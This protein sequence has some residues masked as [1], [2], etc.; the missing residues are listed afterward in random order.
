MLAFIFLVL[1][2]GAFWFLKAL[3]GAASSGSS[4]R[5]RAE[6]RVPDSRRPVATRSQASG[7]RITPRY[8]WLPP[9]ESIEV[10]GTLLNGGMLYV[11]RQLAGVA[12]HYE[13]EPA[14]I[15]PSLPIGIAPPSLGD[16]GMG[17]WP[18]YS[19]IA[20]SARRAYLAWLASGRSQTGVDIGLV[21]LFFY[22]LERRALSE[23]RSSS[24]ARAEL[25]QIAAEVER[26]L[27]IY[28]QN[29]SFRSYC[30]DFLAAVRM[31]AHGD[32][33]DAPPGASRSYEIPFRLKYLLGRRAQEG[34][35]VPSDL[36]FE[37]VES[38]PEIYLRTPAERC[39][40]DFR[41]LFAARYAERFGGGLTLRR[42]KRRLS[43]E[44]RPASPSF[45][46]PIRIDVGD[47]PD[48]SALKQPVDRLRELAATTEAELDSYSRYL[49]RRPEDGD[50]L[51]ALALL[52]TELLR[53]R[54]SPAISKLQAWIE[55]KLSQRNERAVAAREFLAHWPFETV[56]SPKKGE[57]TAYAQLLAKLGVGFEP[58]P[59]F[60]SVRLKSEDQV[61]LFR[62]SSESAAASARYAALT[63]IL[64]LAAAV[65][66]ADGTVSEAEERRLDQHLA[67]NMDLET[68]ERERLSA[69]RT[70]LLANPARAVANRRQIEALK[71]AD[72]AGAA[73]LLVAIASAD[74]R[75]DK[76]EV[77][78][79]EKVYVF[80]GLP[81]DQLYSDLHSIDLAERP[82]IVEP[83]HAGQEYDLPTPPASRGAQLDE[84]RIQ[85]T[86]AETSA[87]NKMLSEVFSDE[88]SDGMRPVDND[89][90][91][92]EGLDAAHARLLSRLRERNTW[93]A[94]EFNEFCQAEGLLPGGAVETLNE[95][96][97]DR[98]D[99]PLVEGEDPVWID[100]ET[101]REI[102]Q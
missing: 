14:L 51:P 8:V 11:G 37:W 43:F 35:P 30:T 41:D 18:S 98:F 40:S 53:N 20:P 27:G 12:S 15:D 24:E 59:R 57:L 84:S 47:L 77:R 5:S 91:P 60:V 64:Q 36:A 10:A 61:V 70:W 68:S 75:I 97:F 80:L 49:G 73:S 90:S 31:L 54:S 3:S 7:R 76:E 22:G 58:D 93:S 85:R 50:S 25:P 42:A 96:A 16:V 23:S 21:F 63:T 45:R 72:K 52:P 1:L 81:S 26:L 39:R 86:W 95:F 34:L 79:L 46:G 78:L 65:T 83:P 32:P 13:A 82:V 94:V 28:G 62:A 100:L 88:A 44:Y 4:H 56:D 66:L 48:V 29:G 69:Y 67:A 89:L 92:I 33:G 9:G 6:P 99:T 102:A 55:D 87:L 19:A 2:V 38:H 71:P 101:A 74:G 17:Y